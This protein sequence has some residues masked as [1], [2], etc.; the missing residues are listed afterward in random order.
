MVPAKLGA[1]APWVAGLSLA[2]FLVV[3]LWLALGFL[4]P[5]EA[6]VH[7]H[8]EEA[9]SLS[10]E[11]FSALVDHFIEENTREDGCVE[12]SSHAHG[13]DG[14]GEVYIMAFMYGYR[15]SEICLKQG[16]TYT[17]KMMSMDVVHG[18]SLTMGSGS[19]MIRLPPGQLVEFEVTFNEPGEYIAYCSF[20]CGVGHYNMAFKIIVEPSAA[21]QEDHEDGHHEEE[22]DSHGHHERGGHH[23]GE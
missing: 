8:G 13:G 4:S 14:H 22:P 6:G 17:F 23:E 19:R 7:A 15:P 12:A 16:E 1:P 10:V 2:I 18:A 20:F 3:P 21:G 9:S 5:S 11:E